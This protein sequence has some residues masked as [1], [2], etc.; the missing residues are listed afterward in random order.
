MINF[1]K[2]IWDTSTKHARGHVD[3]S[4]LDLPPS[5]WPSTLVLN[6]SDGADATFS[7]N[8]FD[9]DRHNEIVSARYGRDWHTVTVYND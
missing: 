4:D 8:G 7:L 6:D 3:A 2:I 5:N 9:Y 1:A